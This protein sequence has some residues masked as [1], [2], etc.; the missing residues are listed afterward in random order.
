VSALLFRSNEDTWSKLKDAYR[1]FYDA[2][3][4]F[5]LAEVDRVRIL[6]VALRNSDRPIAIAM[7][8]YLNIGELEELFEELVFLAS[9]SHGA[10]QLVRD[11]IIRLPREWVLSEIERVAEPLLASGTYDEYRRLLELYAPLDSELTRRLAER[12]IEHPDPDIREAG[13]DFFTHR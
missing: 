4:E 7:L 5:S 9:F 12:A 2:M 1:A 8:P 3:G 10:I 6:K 11:Q 13:Q